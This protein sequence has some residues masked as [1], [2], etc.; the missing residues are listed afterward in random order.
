MLAYLIR[1]HNACDSIDRYADAEISDLSMILDLWVGDFTEKS[2]RTL[3]NIFLQV[4]S[5]DKNLRGYTIP[6]TIVFFNIC[7]SASNGNP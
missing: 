5:T 4:L 2:C 7:I 1:M 6:N 3:L